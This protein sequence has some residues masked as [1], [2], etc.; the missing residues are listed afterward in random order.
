MSEQDRLHDARRARD[1]NADAG[2]LLLLINGG[3]AV[4]MLGFV[5]AI[6]PTGAS[7]SEETTSARAGRKRDDFDVHTMDQQPGEW[8]RLRRGAGQICLSSDASGVA[9]LIEAQPLLL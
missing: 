6:L 5:Q 7:G 2:K 1:A 3:A 8:G 9:R 4:A